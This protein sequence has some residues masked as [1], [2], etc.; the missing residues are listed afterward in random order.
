MYLLLKFC[1][2][3]RFSYPKYRVNFKLEV[4][5]IFHIPKSPEIYKEELKV[6][7]TLAYHIV[8]G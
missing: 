1:H 7:F 4:I 2:E 6:E 5:I 8:R 3:T